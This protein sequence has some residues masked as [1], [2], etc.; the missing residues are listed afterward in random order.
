MEKSA[1]TNWKAFKEV[2]TQIPDAGLQFQYSASKRVN[3]SFHITEIKQCSI[4]SVDCGGLMNK[5]T[6]I[7]MQ[8][9]EPDGV[10]QKE[11]MN[12]KKALSIIAVVEKALSLEPT[13]TVK[14]EFGNSEFDTRQMYPGKMMVDGKNLV[15]D[16]TPD[17]VQCKAIDRG[18]S[19]GATDVKEECCT[20]S[21]AKRETELKNLAV[22]ACCEPGCCN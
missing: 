2:L 12:V 5:W 1:P 15:I 14:I 16:L 7:I 18:G 3:N 11:P 19:C 9:W 17:T 6:E 10:V 13:A 20:T 22:T 8:L 21:A 4:T